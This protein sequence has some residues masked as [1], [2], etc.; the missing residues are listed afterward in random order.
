MVGFTLWL[1]EPD[2]W[3]GLTV[4]LTARLTTEQRA[5]L[6]WAALRSLSPENVEDVANAVLAPL[7]EQR[8]A[9]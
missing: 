1:N 2:A 4:V 5:A 6:A 7:L 3:A 9:A 8:K